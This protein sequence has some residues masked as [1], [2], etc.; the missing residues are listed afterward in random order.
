MIFNTLRTATQA[1]LRKNGMVSDNDVYEIIGTGNLTGLDGIG[2]AMAR[3]IEAAYGATADVQQP[4][5]DMAAD[6]QV[7]R[8]EMVESRLK[9]NG[10][11]G[12]E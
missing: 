8:Y 6:V 5:S 3:E 4:V 7:V 1:N 12:C 2:R 9:S 11:K 10:C